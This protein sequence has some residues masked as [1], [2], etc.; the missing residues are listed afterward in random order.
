MDRSDWPKIV[1]AMKA[2]NYYDRVMAGGAELDRVKDYLRAFAGERS[3]A[4][5]DS[6][7]NPTYPCFPGLGHRPFHDPAASPAVAMLEEAWEKIREE[8]QAL[9]EAAELDYTIASRPFRDPLRPWTWFRR[10]APARAW[11]IYPFYYMGVDVE[12][13]TRRCPRTLAIINALPDLCVDYPWGDAVFSVQGPGSWLPA[14]CSI[15]NLRLRCHLGIRIPGGTGIRVG[16]ETRQWSD[17]KCLLFE[18][19]FEHEVWNRSRER[20][21]VLIVD[22]WHPDLTDI[23]KRVLTA[24]FRKSEVRQIFMRHRINA[25]NSPQTYLPHLEASLAAQ[26]NAPSVREFW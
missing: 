18:D 8:A 9:E 20:R 2:G 6:A 13:V 16:R 4:G 26:D 25:T 5:G 23:E 10:G 19:S 14:H 11:T 21:T 17:G 3:P 24:G 22:F 15:D 1:A 12:A 7:Q